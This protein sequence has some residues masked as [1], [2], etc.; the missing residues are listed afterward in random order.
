MASRK[1]SFLLW[2]SALAFIL[3]CASTV[4]APAPTVDPNE[5]QVW[6]AQT[7]NAAVTQTV[8]AMPTSTP[9]ETPTATPA[10]TFTP[11]PT[12]TATVVFILSTPTLPVF[13]TFTGLS[14]GGGGTS[15]TSSDDF[16]CQVLSVE[17][18]NGTSFN[19]RTNFDAVWRIRNIGQK[20]WDH[21]GVDYS[22]DSGDRIH[23]VERYD[24]S[25]N[26][27]SG[28]T[29]GVI[30][31]MAAPRNAGSYTTRWVL[32]SGRNEFCRMSLTIN[33]R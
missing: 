30:V 13:P 28:Q 3:A 1:L 14:S 29:V 10:N 9:T 5:L 22:Y 19:G 8:A 18:A 16:A 4:G 21:N 32:N 12:N 7:A 25:A 24:L 17:P 2:S 20:M 23:K 33:V 11:S 15:G 6:I 26:V 31:D 27:R